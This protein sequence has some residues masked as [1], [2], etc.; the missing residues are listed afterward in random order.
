MRRDNELGMAIDELNTVYLNYDF[1]YRLA[2]GHNFDQEVSCLRILETLFHECTHILQFKGMRDGDMSDELFMLYKEEILREISVGYYSN[3]YHGISFEQ[4][5]RVN[6]T[7]ELA[8]F[9]ETFFPY[10]QNAID[11]FRNKSIMEKEQEFKS[12][13]LFELSDKLSVDE[14]LEKVISIN[15]GILEQYPL[16]NREFNKD[17]SRKNKPVLS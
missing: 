13:V 17:G 15:P 11:S 1:I 14:I 16:L 12:K 5:A 9:L 4:D 8:N 10:M 6:G 3:N 7:G 2:N